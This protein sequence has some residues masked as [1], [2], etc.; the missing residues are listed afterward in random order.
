MMKYD[1]WG[2]SI[3]RLD[4]EP[5]GAPFGAEVMPALSRF[6]KLFRL[7]DERELNEM[8][9]VDATKKTDCGSQLE[10]GEEL[11]KGFDRH[12]ALNPAL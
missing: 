3:P 11:A 10:V 1:H 5:A 7:P 8:W 4:A 6:F 2:S 12:V 9:T